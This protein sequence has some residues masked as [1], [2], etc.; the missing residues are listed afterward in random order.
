MFEK[1]FWSKFSKL[2][3]LDSYP[4]LPC[5]YCNSVNLEPDISSFSTR[6]L[7]GHARK[8]YIDR[9][10]DNDLLNLVKDEDNSFLKLAVT[11]VTIASESGYGP[12]QFIAFFKC[13]TCNESVSATGVAK[14]PIDKTNQIRQIKV[15]SFS[16]PIPLFPLNNTTPNSVNEELLSSFNHYFFDTCSAGSRLRRAIEKLCVEL[17]FSHGNLHR[18]IQNMAKEFP[19]EA[20]WLESL[21][22]VGNEATHADRVSEDDLL[23]SYKVFEVVLD[24][25]RRKHLD[26]E[27]D[28]TVLKIENKYKK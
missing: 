3:Q 27:I 8:A 20:R 11:F 7:S 21:K 19:Q 26:P 25:F 23:N 12:S 6:A 15:E 2:Q 4:A 17:G 28:N 5:P 22:L 1:E 10:R 24:I 14:I 16:P 13:N 18:R 9:F